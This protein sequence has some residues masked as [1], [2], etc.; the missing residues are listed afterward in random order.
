[1]TVENRNFVRTRSPMREEIGC[2]EAD[3]TEADC[4]EADCTEAVCTE[5]VCT[6]ADCIDYAE[7]LVEHCF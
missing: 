3:C 2:T 6:E 7:K 4:T 5:A 1:M